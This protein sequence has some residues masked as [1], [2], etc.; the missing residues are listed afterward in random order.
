MLIMSVGGPVT[1]E[2]M[3]DNL[4]VVGVVVLAGSAVSV[5]SPQAETKIIMITA[6]ARDFMVRPF[7]LIVKYN[8]VSIIHLTQRVSKH[9]LL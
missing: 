5:A 6:K 8:C 1:A 4:F 3:F 9:L 7:V 2:A